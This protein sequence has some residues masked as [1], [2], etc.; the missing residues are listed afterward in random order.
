MKII[1]YLDHNKDLFSNNIYKY[2]VRYYLTSY[3]KHNN[4]ITK[5]IKT[6]KYFVTSKGPT[7]VLLP[8]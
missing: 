1:I 4:Q 5:T 6:K 3:R 8:I 2:A 7:R